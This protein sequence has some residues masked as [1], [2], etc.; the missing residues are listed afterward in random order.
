MALRSCCIV[1]YFTINKHFQKTRQLRH[2]I[3]NLW[4]VVSLIWRL[5]NLSL[6]QPEPKRL[7]PHQVLSSEGQVRAEIFPGMFRAISVARFIF[8][9]QVSFWAQITQWYLEE[10]I[11]FH[12]LEK[13]RLQILIGLNQL[14]LTTL[15]GWSGFAGKQAVIFRI[16]SSICFQEL[17]ESQLY[18]E[19]F[20]LL[21]LTL[22]PSSNTERLQ[23]FID[24]GWK[25]RKSNT[26][27]KLNPLH[28]NEG[29]VPY[30]GL[31]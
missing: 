31:D 14:S 1:W 22:Y 21:H 7:K 4:L 27:W 24:S 19:I 28:C 29:L 23:N 25:N 6:L 18:H 20:V 30:D 26:L 17:C 5:M 12:K 10:V 16:Y 3:L 15:L 9:V 8:V 13:I 2:R 11:W